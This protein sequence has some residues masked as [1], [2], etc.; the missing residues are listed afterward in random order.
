MNANAPIFS[1]A[2]SSPD[3][4]ARSDVWPAL[5]SVYHEQGYDAGYRRGVNDT[6]ATVLEA[7]ND[8]AR[9]RDGDVAE[10]RRLLY[11]FSEF[12]EQRAGTHSRTVD[13][14][15]VDGLGI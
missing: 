14:H 15:F 11:A 12:L 4:T 9:L 7:V 3:S 1:S 2:D 13:Q 6:L 10:T 8:F 5:A